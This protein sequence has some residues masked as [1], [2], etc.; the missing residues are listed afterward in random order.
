[1]WL[2]SKF[3]SYLDKVEKEILKHDKALRNKAVGVVMTEVKKTL[4]SGSELPQKITGNLLAGAKKENYKYSSV[5]GFQAPAYHAWLVEEGH[6]IV[7]NGVKVGEAK[8]H[9]FLKPAFEAKK[10]EIIKILSEE[11]V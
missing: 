6:D 5:V 9:P 11:R 10:D 3:T 8:P 7:R 1:M 4:K 2:E